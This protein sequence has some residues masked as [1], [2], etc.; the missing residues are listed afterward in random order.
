LANEGERG[1]L[2]DVLQPGV[3]FINPKLQKVTLIEIGFNEFS[4]HHGNKTDSQISF[5]SDTGFMIR[6]GVTIIWG[7]DPR[8]AS[9]IINEFGNTDG[10]LEKVI[11]PQLRSICRNIGS[12][13]AA[14]DF[15]QGE[16]REQFQNA[17]KQ[18]VQRVCRQKNI[19]VLLALV[20]EIE[21]MP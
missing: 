5:P 20:R 10:V 11:E 16:K 13:Y 15:I 6:V 14:R 7:I 19:E 4:Q 9:Q 12:T 18:E 2:Q 1:T 21:V 8:H 17:L 3:Y